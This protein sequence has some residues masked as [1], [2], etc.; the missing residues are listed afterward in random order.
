MD[1]IEITAKM[2]KT[3]IDAKKAVITLELEYDS[4]GQ[5]PALARMTG[6]SVNVVLYP[7]QT[8]MDV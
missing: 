5:I 4:W 6:Q 1:Q 3:S 2:A 8:S 7:S